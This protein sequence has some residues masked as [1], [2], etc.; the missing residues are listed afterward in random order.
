MW[1]TRT[2]EVPDGRAVAGLL[3][4]VDHH[5]GAE[6]AEVAAVVLHARIIASATGAGD[7]GEVLSTGDALLEGE[8]LVPGGQRV[9][10]RGLGADADEQVGGADL[11][12]GAVVGLADH[13][14]EQVVV[15]E[16]GTGKLLA[17]AGQFAH[18]RGGRVHTEVFGSL[19]LELEVNEELHVLIEARWGDEAVPVVL[20]EDGGEIVRGH[21]FTGHRHDGLGLGSG[22]GE[23]ETEKQSRQGGQDRS[24]RAVV[25]HRGELT[26]E[27]SACLSILSSPKTV[28]SRCC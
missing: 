5:E 7:G 9:G 27:F 1:A 6:P 14:V 20:L 16:I 18:E 28:E 21:G 12:E 23:E 15:D 17:V 26:A 4:G 19:N 2:D 13:G 24:G 11:L 10:R 8:C 25:A 22:Q 3:E